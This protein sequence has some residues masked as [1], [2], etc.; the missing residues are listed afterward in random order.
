MSG[1]VLVL[2]SLQPFYF[3]FPSCTVVYVYLFFLPDAISTKA[4]CKL[5]SIDLLLLYM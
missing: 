1:S 3:L 2:Y 5:K 4:L